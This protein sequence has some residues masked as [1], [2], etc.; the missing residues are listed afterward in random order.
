ML[1][2]AKPDAKL[3]IID[4]M[5]HVLKESVA[6]RTKNLETYTNPDLPLKKE[7]VKA[8]IKFINK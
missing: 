5:N 6:D 7:L 4:N 8:I 2:A 3:L 1:A